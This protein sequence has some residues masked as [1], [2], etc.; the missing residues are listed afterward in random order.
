MQAKNT[1]ALDISVEGLDV[2][3]TVDADPG[4]A[5]PFV[6]EYPMSLTTSSEEHI[7]RYSPTPS[8]EHE[9]AQAAAA[10]L[11]GALLTSQ[12]CYYLLQ[13][14]HVLVLILMKSYVAHMLFLGCRIF[15]RLTR[16]WIVWRRRLG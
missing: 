8:V 10:K 16:Q 5:Q 2:M 14:G 9:A 6:L 15:L 3:A 12:V 13:C 1:P 7:Q 11:Y 4:A